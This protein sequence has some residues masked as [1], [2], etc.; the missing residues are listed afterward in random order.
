MIDGAAD[1]EVTNVQVFNGYVLHI[2]RLKYGQL[3][4]GDSVVS[5]Y[6]EVSQ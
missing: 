6:D 2:G 4:V 3:S 1:F 5:S